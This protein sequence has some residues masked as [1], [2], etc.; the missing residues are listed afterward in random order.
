MTT[1]YRD[2]QGNVIRT[3]AGTKPRNR[4]P[5]KPVAPAPTPAPAPAPSSKAA[6]PAPTEK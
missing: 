2:K 6:A 4:Q 5:T 3:D 1:V